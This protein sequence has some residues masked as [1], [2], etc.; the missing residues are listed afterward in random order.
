MLVRRRIALASV[1]GLALVSGLTTSA[2][3]GSDGRRASAI[4]NSRHSDL[5][6]AGA[7]SFSRFP[8]YWLGDSFERLPLKA[9]TQR[10]EPLG[11]GEKVRADYVGF[12]Y[13]DCAASGENG[14]PPPL[15][16]QVWPACVRSLADYTLTPAGEP[17]A[18]EPTMVRGVPGAFFENGLRLE[19][20]TGNATVVIFGLDRA[21][22]QRAAAALRAANALA[23]PA[24]ML[25][26]PAR[27]AMNGT[28][29]CDQ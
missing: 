8:L 26:P 22:I 27:G 15:E 17:L 25:P 5:D 3:T 13:G 4:F 19:L 11:R 7:R 9:I 6:P 14:C 21:Q 28:L 18:H 29:A 12:I 2:G 24:P 16:I 23:S 10:D 1:V 20:Y